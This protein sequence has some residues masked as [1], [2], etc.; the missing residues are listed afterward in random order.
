MSDA[1]QFH[2]H[3]LPTRIC[4]AT[5]IVYLMGCPS[6]D[7]FLLP[8][9]PQV[10]QHGLDLP[11]SM[12]ETILQGP[13]LKC[14]DVAS[15]DGNGQQQ[16]CQEDVFHTHCSRPHSVISSN[17][18]SL[19][20][21]AVSS[22]RTMLTKATPVPNQNEHPNVL[23]MCHLWIHTYPGYHETVETVA[24]GMAQGFPI[25]QIPGL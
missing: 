3:D 12:P 10:G 24:G 1:F 6:G 4:P 19:K 8:H 9:P 17:G 5:L 11:L 13:H 14:G 18:D 2:R 15:T 16:R 7:E 21:K 20:Q 23:F 22:E 25:P